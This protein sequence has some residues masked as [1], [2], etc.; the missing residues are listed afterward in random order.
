MIKKQ[1]LYRE[2]Q[3]PA[4]SKEELDEFDPYKGDI[5]SLGVTY[6][7]CLTNVKYYK[8]NESKKYFKKC[9]QELRKLK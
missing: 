2:N 1:Y 6:V 4:P 3:G 9:A 7:K 5:F 8:I